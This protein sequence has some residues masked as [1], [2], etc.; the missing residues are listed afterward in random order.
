M[1][2]GLVCAMAQGITQRVS[3][4]PAGRLP[5][6]V[7]FFLWRSKK[8]MPGSGGWAMEAIRDRRIASLSADIGVNCAVICCMSAEGFVVG[9]D[10]R[11][12]N[13]GE[14]GKVIA[15]RTRH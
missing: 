6:H 14:R 15:R 5:R 7:R 10:S 11:I 8:G 2:I 12:H 13:L 4:V 1:T 9:E 3:P